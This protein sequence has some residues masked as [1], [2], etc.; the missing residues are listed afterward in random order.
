MPG[1]GRAYQQDPE[2]RHASARPIAKRNKTKSKC[3]VNTRDHPARSVD[4]Y[5][6]NRIHL[7]LESH[8][9][10]PGR[11]DALPGGGRTP[12]CRGHGGRARE[13]R[14]RTKGSKPPLTVK[15]AER[16]ATRRRKRDLDV[17]PKTIKYEKKKTMCLHT[18]IVCFGLAF[19]F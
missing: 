9:P 7:C 16:Q 10:A 13:A 1:P 8:L 15:S 19:F 3:G 18:S 6:D 2:F 11:Q 4:R 5:A 14:R 12:R 17:N